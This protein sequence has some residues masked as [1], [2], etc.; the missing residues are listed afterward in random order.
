[1]YVDVDVGRRHVEVDEIG[2][3]LVGGYQSREGLL[4]GTVEIG[5]PH[6]AVVDE[7][8]L[9]Q[10]ALARSLGLAHEA[11]DA[12]HGGLNLHGKEAVGKTV[13]EDAGDALFQARRGEAE[14]RGAVV[15]QR[16]GDVGVHEHDAFQ[17]GG[18]VG[19][20]RLV[21]LQE[22]TA[23]RDIEEEVLDDEVGAYG[24]GRGLLRHHPRALEDEM[25]SQ[26][27]VGHA[28]SQFHLR[29]RG[30]GG[31][32]LTAEAH[33]GEGEE[34]GGLLDLAGSMTLEG[35]ARIGLAHPLAV[36]DDLQA[37]ATGIHGNDVDA[38]GTGIH[39][40]LHQLFDNGG[41]ALDDFASCYLVGDGI[42]KKMNGV[43]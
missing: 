10:A 17:L 31:Q 1:M 23:C 28:R 16:E 38:M 32:R 5:M 36:I 15:C 40:V 14:Q 43:H 22:L 12:H 25:C 2:H 19:E 20:F 30:D 3:L 42:R 9:L 21:G 24:T 41:G 34:V 13:A 18:D 33:G 8:V 39:S 35:H 7:E 37:G 29:H 26:L 11:A 27:A 4:H 6:I